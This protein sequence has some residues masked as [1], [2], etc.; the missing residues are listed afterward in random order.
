MSEIRKLQVRLKY[1]NCEFGKSVVIEAGVRFKITDGGTLKVGE[2]T[3]FKRN[4]VVIVKRG[5]LLVGANSFIGWGSIIC[6]N[7]QI[8]IGD[9]ALVAEYVTIRDQNHGMDPAIGPYCSQPMTTS[10]VVIHDNVW[11]GAK[12]SILAGASIGSNS[13]VGSNSVVTKNIEPNIVVAGVPAR[14]LREL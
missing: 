2:G 4:C 14:K 1:P 3:T 13:I 5:T 7:E 6:A 11:I 8:K 10:P 9:N 12:A